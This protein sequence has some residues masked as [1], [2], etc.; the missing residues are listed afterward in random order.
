[1]RQTKKSVIYILKAIFFV[2]IKVNVAAFVYFTFEF[3]RQ[4]RFLWSTKLLQISH[5]TVSMFSVIIIL[6]VNIIKTASLGI[7]CDPLWGSHDS[8]SAH[9]R[10]HLCPILWQLWF[11][12]HKI[13]HTIWGVIDYLYYHTLVE[14]Q[15][16][17]NLLLTCHNVSYGEHWTIKTLY[18][19]IWNY[20]VIFAYYFYCDVTENTQ[21]ATCDTTPANIR[22]CTNVSSMLAHHL[23]RWPS[24]FF[25]FISMCIQITHRTF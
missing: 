8:Q 22:R 7:S 9:I 23:R 19:F 18:R 21:L 16:L 25:F 6:T 12:C 17:R 3:A 13:I 14:K 24:I 2:D 1:M 15:T 10:K 11:I 5:F 20:R 4:Q